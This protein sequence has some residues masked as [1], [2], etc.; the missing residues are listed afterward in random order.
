LILVISFSS[1][2]YPLHEKGKSKEANIEKDVRIEKD[3]KNKLGLQ[4]GWLA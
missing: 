1:Q 3:N 2:I 4:E